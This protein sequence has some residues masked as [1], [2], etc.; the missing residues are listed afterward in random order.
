MLFR[1]FRRDDEL[2]VSA[3]YLLRT[4]LLDFSDVELPMVSM[5]STQGR[6]S[7][8]TTCSPRGN[9]ASMKPAQEPGETTWD[10]G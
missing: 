7:R 9:G 1:F 10:N 5:L 8:L 6:D 3:A 4:T 2:S